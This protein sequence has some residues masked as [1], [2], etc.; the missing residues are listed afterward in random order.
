MSYEFLYQI[1]GLG[2]YS[3][4]KFTIMSHYRCSAPQPKTHGTSF[5]D[6]YCNIIADIP[7]PVPWYKYHAPCLCATRSYLP[8]VLRAKLK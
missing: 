6:Y 1:F 3:T 4:V 5:P 7:V 8:T 2:V